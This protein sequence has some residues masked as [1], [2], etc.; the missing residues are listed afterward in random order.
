MSAGNAWAVP[1]ATLGILGKLPAP[2]TFGSLAGIL[3]YYIVLQPLPSVSLR[4]ILT[5]LAV[6]AAVKICTMASHHL[7]QKDPGEIVLDEF[8]SMPII[9]VGLSS[10]LVEQPLLVT[11]SGFLLFRTLDILKPFGIKRLETLPGGLG[12]V[13]DD[14]AAALLATIILFALLSNK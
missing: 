14:V 5:V 8:V 6:T 13:L 1:M 7:Q 11:A 10:F 4:I 12:I 9:L 2:G 3:W